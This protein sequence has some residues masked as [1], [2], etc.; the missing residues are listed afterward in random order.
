MGKGAALRGF[1][2]I[3]KKTKASYPKAKPRGKGVYPA[4]KPSG[5]TIKQP[6]PKWEEYKFPKIEERIRRDAK[7]ETVGIAGA[8]GAAGAVG[9][10]IGKSKAKKEAKAKETK[11]KLKKSTEEHKKKTKEKREKHRKPHA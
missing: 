5:P 3:L 2:A 9:Y 6:K 4:T 7:R 8:M 10:T 1:G 11:E